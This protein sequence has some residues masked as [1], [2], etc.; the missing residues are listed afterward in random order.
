MIKQLARS[1][2]GRAA[3]I[4][5]VFTIFV[6]FTILSLPISQK[7]PIDLID[8]F[9]T[10]TSAT[11]VCG[12]LTVPLSNFTSFGQSV[13]IALAQIGGLGLI[14]LTL[15]ASALFAEMGMGTQCL[16]G[17]ILETNSLKE[18]RPILIFIIGFTLVS[19]VIGALFFLPFF[20]ENYNWPEAISETIFHSI[21]SF[22]NIG[23]IRSELVLNYIQ[24]SYV[25]M[26][27]TAVLI[28]LGGTGFLVWY[29]LIKYLKSKWEQK[30]HALSLHSRVVFST[31]LYLILLSS[32][33][34]LIFEKNE[35]FY[36]LNYF[37]SYFYSLF[38]AISIKSTGFLVYN[39]NNYCMS[40][41][42]LFMAICFIGS[43]P[44]SA[45]SGIKVTTFALAISTIRSSI[46]GNKS[47]DIKARSIPNTLVW[48]ALTII[49]LSIIW[50]FVVLVILLKTES[51]TFKELLLE[52]VSSFSTLGIS[53]KNS[54]NFSIY[55]K[56]LLSMTMIAGRVGAM[57]ILIAFSKNQKSKDYSYPMEK[58][59]LN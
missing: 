2:P 38:T 53:L 46:H 59:L 35:S 17:Y 14:T 42:L 13:I 3:L 22:C 47:V 48:R 36:S 1:Y 10:A 51:G 27:G 54:N 25:F 29:D 45:G 6:G 33:L 20:L 57:G 50:I 55:G 56:I 40:T 52:T 16:A 58:V 19:E 7:N 30:R 41:L 43:A 23:L 24:N 28:L 8:L 5:L 21:S 9:F 44:G 15:I 39:I 26:S 4:A 37:K 49:T 32:I 12:S 18:I 34:I 11:C 31:T